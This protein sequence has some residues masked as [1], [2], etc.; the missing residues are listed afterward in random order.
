MTKMYRTPGAFKAALETRLKRDAA[1]HH[2][3]MSRRRQLEIFYRFLARV[4]HVLG[5]RVVLKGG[6]VLELRLERART[7]KDVDLRMMGSSDEALEHLQAAG[8]LELEDYMR[9]EVQRDRHHPDILSDGMKYD[10]H[11]FRA[12]CML[13]GQIYGSPFGV[14]V[15]FG[16]PLTGEPDEIAASDLLR[17]AGIEPPVLR[18]YPIV[19]HIAEKLH[20]YTVQHESE[21]SRV[22]DLPDIGLLALIG[23]LDAELLRSALAQTFAFRDTHLLPEALPAP[24]TSWEQPYAKIA[25]KDELPWPTISEVHEEVSLFLDPVLAG[26]P[27]GTWDPHSWIWI[28]FST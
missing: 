1:T 16:D 6:L 21:N 4:T 17:F 28:E 26:N 13:A 3:D 27:L 14:D 7:T 20:A 11:R 12:Q 10:G 25:S 15:G 24:P 23:E 2:F 19:S 18:V 8:A 9:F 22:K 5:D